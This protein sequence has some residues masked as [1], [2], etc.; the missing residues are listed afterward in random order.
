MKKCNCGKE[1]CKQAKQC[2]S[3]SNKKR[4][5][6]DETKRRI[7]ISHMEEKNPMWKGDAV[8]YC[9]LHEWVR[10]RKHAPLLC[11]NC[12]TCPPM[13]LA[14][15]GDRYTRNLDD[16][17]YLCR[18]CHM[19]KDGR[20]KRLKKKLTKKRNVYAVYKMRKL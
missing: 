5:C 7:S 12:R 1:I 3:C 13:D 11:E 18:K 6:T 19:E 20:L 17:E 4:V 9:S 14:A 16:W 8:G 10:N 2:K 15:I